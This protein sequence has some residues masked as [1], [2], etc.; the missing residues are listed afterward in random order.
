MKRLQDRILEN[1]RRVLARMQSENDT[2][3]VTETNNTWFPPRPIIKKLDR[4]KR[5]VDVI[6]PCKTCGNTVAM[7]LNCI[8]SLRQSE[9]EI[10]FNV[11]IVESGENIIDVGQNDTIKYPKAKFCYN[12]AL[13]MGLKN[14]E[15]NW[16]VLA[17]NDLIFKKGW[18]TEIIIAHNIRKDI[19]SFSPWNDMW[20]WH[21]RYYG[22]VY[23][24]ILEGH[25]IGIELAG[26][27]I[28]ARRRI[29]ER[30]KLSERVDFWY[31]DNV[32]ADD[33]L[34]H[35]IKH[36]LVTGSKVD[37]I[38]SQTHAVTAEESYISRLQYLG[39]EV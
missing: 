36:A 26:W 4:T 21:R 34:T 13:N 10:D 15:S 28:V 22:D 12:H 8:Q 19:E 1:N 17:N 7:T 35:G 38:V 31:S 14:T 33:L 30:V 5:I 32:Y 20:D 3:M 9:D 39:G 2:L 29:F 37:H 25:R 27:C 23:P 18:M 6:I 24:D 11:V 16:V